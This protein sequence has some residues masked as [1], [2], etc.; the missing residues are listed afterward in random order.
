MYIYE[1]CEKICF[2]TNQTFTSS[3]SLNRFMLFLRF[4]VMHKKY[5]GKANSAIM[6]KICII[7][8]QRGMLIRWRNL[9]NDASVIQYLCGS[10][11]M[12]LAQIHM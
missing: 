2:N 5:V 6:E 1:I 3:P 12:V 11:T 9:P 8:K 10:H 4:I 7:L